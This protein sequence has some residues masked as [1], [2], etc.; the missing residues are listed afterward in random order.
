[1]AQLKVLVAGD[2]ASIHANR[3]VCLL[4]E[5]GYDVRMFQSAHYFVQEEHLRNTIVYI[6]N[7]EP[8]GAW[9][10]PVNGNTVVAGFPLEMGYGGR[11]HAIYAIYLWLWTRLTGGVAR[12]VLGRGAPKPARALHLRKVIA[13]WRPGLIISLKMQDDGYTVAEALSTPLAG[14]RPKWVHFTWGTDIEFFGKHPDYAPAHLPRIRQVLENCDYLISDCNRDQLQAGEF[15][16]RG[17]KLGQCIAPGGFD[18]ALVGMLREEAGPARDVILV[19]GREGNFVG[20]ALNV[21]KALGRIAPLLKGYRIRFVMATGPVREA[22][23]ELAK[24]HGLDCEVSP[25]LA[26]R[27]LLLCFG[28]SRLAISASDVDGTPSFLIEAMAMGAL[29]VHSDMVSIREWVEDGVNGLLFPVDDVAALASCIERAL[30]DDPLLSTARER[31][32]ELAQERMDRNRI[33]ATVKEWIERR[34]L[35]SLP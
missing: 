32:W 10:I 18:L 28:R 30:S 29:P 14:P 19:K 13:R 31:N 12:R 17:V 7:I 25:F 1:M 34:V 4:Q 11:W 20:K 22:V 3:F 6:S 5:I 33:R 9:E 26:Y 2:P 27:D 8:G 35:A 24:E 15:G 21:I 16:F 23:Q